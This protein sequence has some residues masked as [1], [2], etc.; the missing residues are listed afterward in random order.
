MNM[1]M[2]NNPCYNCVHFDRIYGGCLKYK[3]FFKKPFRCSAYEDWRG[4]GRKNG[5]DR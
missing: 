3:V 5:S 1:S 2:K 4:K